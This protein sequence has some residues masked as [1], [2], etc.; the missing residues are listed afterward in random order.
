MDIVSKTINTLRFL[1]IDQVNQANS[2]H[3]GA[4]MGVA[5]I[6]YVLF[7]KI[8]KHSPKNPLFFNRDRFI[9]S[10]GHASALLYST[11]FLSGYKYSIDDLKSFRQMNSKT[12][13]HPEI[14]PSMGIEV[15]TGPLGQGFAN[16]VGMAISEK[17]LSSKFNIDSEIINHYIYSIVGDGDLQ[18]GISSEAASL[19]GTL[20]LG[21]LIYIYDSNNITIDGSNDLAFTEN[22]AQRFLAYGWEVIENIDGNDIKAIETS[23]TKAKNNLNQPS[24]IIANTIIGYGSPNKSGK[25]TAHGEPL[26][27]NE[28]E[29]TRKKLNWEYQA[30]EIPNEVV[31]HMSSIRKEGEILEDNWNNEISEYKAKHPDLYKELNLLMNNKLPNGWAKELDD[32]IKENNEPEAT[33]AS[34]GLAINMLSKSLFN[35]LGGSADL[36]TSTNTNINDSGNFSKKLPTGRNIKFGVREH[37]MGGIINGIAAHGSFIPFGGTF[38]IFSD[39]MRGSIRLS[40]LSGLNSIWILTHDSIGLGEDGPTHQPI[41]QLMSLRGIPDLKVF[42][43]A[44]RKE[45]LLSWKAAITNKSNPSAMILSRQAVPSLESIT[46]LQLNE[47]DFLRG[48]YICYKNSDSI[49]EITFISTGSEVA[50]TIEAAK[51]FSTQYKVRV[52][53]MPCWEIFDEQNKEYQEEIISNKSKLIISIEAGIGLG[54]QKYTKN[55]DTIISIDTFGKSAKGNEVLDKFGF[56]TDRIID[57]TKKIIKNSIK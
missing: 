28:T 18:E 1:S 19:A 32:V 26:G 35:L 6:A 49:P 3:P 22:V 20:G 29:L 48:A 14:N 57:K 36:T 31:E 33:R 55:N 17:I 8:M 37:G 11:L 43:P 34:S 44:D 39:Y 9:L 46:K 25:E 52:V 5:G 40:A 2:G 53:S 12:P 30:F 54:W 10:N 38:L 45:T 51:H 23:I 7:K 56:S 16:G 24:L 47:K 27:E 42:R 41:S 15:T 50:P 4:P 21:K 13:G